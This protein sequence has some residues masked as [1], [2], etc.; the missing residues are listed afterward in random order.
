MATLSRLT[1]WV[2][3]H[4]VT[5]GIILA[6]SLM[7][8]LA[9]GAMGVAAYGIREAARTQVDLFQHWSRAQKS[10]NVQELTKADSD[11]KKSEVDLTMLKQSWEDGKKKE[12]E[13]GKNSQ[14]HFFF[15]F[16]SS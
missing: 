7:F 16:L 14:T 1:L 11:A 3:R 5:A 4:M 2:R 10:V 6:F 15:F 8:I 13:G 9:A 12:K